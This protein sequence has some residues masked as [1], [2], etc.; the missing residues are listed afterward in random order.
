MR[1]IEDDRE[2]YRCQ[3]PPENSAATLIVGKKTHQVAVLDTSR[4]GFTVRTARGLARRLRTGAKYE[5]HFAGE[6]WEVEKVSQYND[7]T[8]DW[9]VGFRRI[10]ELT[11]FKTPSGLASTLFGKSGVRTDQTLLL[12]LALSFVLCVLCLPG[13]GD[14]LG[15]APLV[16]DGVKHVVDE[17][18]ETID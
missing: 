8:K 17:V 12:Y 4:N 5:I 18:W 11:K 15:T 9:H 6:K 1:R 10:R 7:G 13:L 16:R 14:Q 2:A 3:I